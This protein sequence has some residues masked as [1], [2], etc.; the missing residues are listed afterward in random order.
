MPVPPD[1]RHAVKTTRGPHDHD[2]W[3]HGQGR[4]AHTSAQPAETVGVSQRHSDRGSDD[5]DDGGDERTALPVY[6]R[7]ADLVR[8]N[9]VGSWT[10]LSRL[11]GHENFPP[12]VMLSRNVRA[13]R[14]DEVNAW[15]DARPSAK[16]VMPPGATRHG[17]KRSE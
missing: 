3:P 9:V 12:G 8:A 17:R 15:L 5:D 13:W 2:T 4:L 6:V 16:K 14:L 10:Q 7:F 11:I 1:Q